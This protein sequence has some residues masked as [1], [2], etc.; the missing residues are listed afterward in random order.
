MAPERAYIE[1]LQVVLPRLGLRWPGFRKVRGQVIKR[2]K[3][4]LRVLHL[5]DLAGYAAYLDTHPAEW[6]VLD[7]MCR[8]SMS[9][10][11]RDKGVFVTLR[12]TLLPHIPP[13]DLAQERQRFADHRRRFAMQRRSP[14]QTK[15]Q[16]A[17]LRHM[18]ET[19]PATGTG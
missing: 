13:E 19:L 16:F 14:R 1:F 10:F 15:T 11:Y 17:Q 6:D 9:R 8:I 2:L 18:W 7:A 12:E 5:Q 4:R 3:R